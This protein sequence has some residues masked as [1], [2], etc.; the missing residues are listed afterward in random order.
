MNERSMQADGAPTCVRH[1]RLISDCQQTNKC[2]KTR[3]VS[4]THVLY[5]ETEV[6]EYGRA[7]L[8]SKQRSSDR[9]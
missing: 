1:L 9:K 7:T 5:F 3:P 8:T 6:T 2:Y 4:G